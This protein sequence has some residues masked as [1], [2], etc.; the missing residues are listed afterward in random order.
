VV[1]NYLKGETPPPFDLLYWNSD[2]TN[3]PG[4]LYVWYLRNT[5]LENKLIKPGNATICGEKMDLRKVDVP[6]Y[7]YG[8]REDHIVPITAA[9]ASTHVFTGP[10]RFV[11]GASGHIAGVINPPASGKRSHWVSKSSEFPSTV[12]EWTASD[13]EKT[14]SWWPD[15]YAWLKKHAGQQVAAPKS[16]GRGKHKAIEPAPGRYVK[17]KAD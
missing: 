1:G 5:Y 8:S 14:G 9:Y 2:A 4:P 6:I 12:E 7:I 16:Y 13:T 10:K 17:V 15:W 3:L 11:M